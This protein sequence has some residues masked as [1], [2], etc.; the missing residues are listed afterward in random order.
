MLSEIL[1]QLYQKFQQNLQQLREIVAQTDPD[2]T[3]LR[4]FFLETQQFFQ[5]Q[6]IGAEGDELPAAVHPQVHAYQT[7]INKQL[8]LLGQDLMFLQAA[9]Q[10]D[11]VQQRQAQIL[12]RLET[13]LRYC[14][15][16]LQDEPEQ[17]A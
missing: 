13:L 14:D 1:L 4:Q 2:Q 9:R 3:A 11:T 5:V 6:I 16:L 8:R 7:E 17:K 15:A 10:S 12:D